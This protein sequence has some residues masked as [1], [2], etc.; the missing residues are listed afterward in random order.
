MKLVCESDKGKPIGAA[1]LFIVLIA[2][3]KYLQEEFEGRV[4]DKTSQLFRSLQK[5]NSGF[6][7]ARLQN[8]C[9]AAELSSIANRFQNLSRPNYRSNYNNNRGHG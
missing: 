3:L 1:Q 7:D 6:E 9:V 5:H 8:V 2:K 4:D